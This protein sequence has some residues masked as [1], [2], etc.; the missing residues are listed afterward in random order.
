M[1]RAGAAVMAGKL[2]VAGPAAPDWPVPGASR[3]HACQGGLRGPLGTRDIEAHAYA[4]Q[5]PETDH[6]SG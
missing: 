2:A 6:S 4:R 3:C 5:T 1:A